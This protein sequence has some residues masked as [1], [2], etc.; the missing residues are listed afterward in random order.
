MSRKKATKSQRSQTAKK[1]VA[2]TSADAAK[3]I[4]SGKLDTAT[5]KMA[6][7]IPSGVAWSI[8]DRI[9]TEESS[10]PRK[11]DP[12]KKATPSAECSI[13]A[14]AFREARRRRHLKG[15]TAPALIVLVPGPS[16]IVPV[17]ALFLTRFGESWQAVA[18][19]A[20][21]TPLQKAERNNDV[22]T[23][24]AHGRPVIGVAVDRDALLSVLTTAADLTIRIDTPRVVTIRRAIRMFTRQP[25]PIDIDE[26]IAFGLEFHD[27]VAAFRTNSSPA[28]ILSRLRNAAAIVGGA[29]T[30]ERLPQ[31]EQAVEYGA[32]RTWGLALARDIADYRVGRLDWQ[33]VDRGAVLFSEPGLGKSLF[34]RILASR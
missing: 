14:A 34:A 5:D 28:E 12:V 15:K 24:L 25:V 9:V 3:R 11:P 6:D 20:P 32:A 29:G 33:D 10:P 31:L 27:L 30:R 22:A 4:S 8:P 16:W 2:R 23:H 19:D 18:T 13:V 7:L 21:K 17:R 26:K 1:G